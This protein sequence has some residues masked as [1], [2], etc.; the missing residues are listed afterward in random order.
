MYSQAPIHKQ[1]GRHS[2]RWRNIEHC[3]AEAISAWE[4]EVDV[5]EDGW[6]ARRRAGGRAVGL[7]NTPVGTNIRE[8]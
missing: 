6:D 2:G 4:G 7:S 1:D 8:Q 3:G 5:D